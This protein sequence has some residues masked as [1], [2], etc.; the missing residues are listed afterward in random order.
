MGAAKALES[1]ARQFAPQSLR[2]Y[3]AATLVELAEA[4]GGAVPAEARETLE[5]LRA[6]PWLARA[7]ALERVVTV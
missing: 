5:R 3:E 7:D 1:A 2:F 4:T 6:Q